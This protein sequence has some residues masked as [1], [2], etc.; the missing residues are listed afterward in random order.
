MTDSLALR[1]TARIGVERV[2][3]RFSVLY[4]R[5]KR[6]VHSL[7]SLTHGPAMRLL[8]NRRLDT[9]GLLFSSRL[10]DRAVLFSRPRGDDRSFPA[11]KDIADGCV[12][13]EHDDR[14][15]VPFF[16]CLRTCEMCST[17]RIKD[18]SR[19]IVFVRRIPVAMTYNVRYSSS[20]RYYRLFQ[21][22]EVDS[23]TEAFR[24]KL[25]TGG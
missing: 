17:R 5:I 3:V 13:E 9:V 4:S 15:Q 8:L 23:S 14:W 16:S 25:K 12:R 24:I 20:S 18:G 2:K 11:G 6:D 19:Q 21:I 22:V 10:P 7:R 1:T